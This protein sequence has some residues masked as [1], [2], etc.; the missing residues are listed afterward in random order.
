MSKPHL[1]LKEVKVSA[2]IWETK[3][4]TSGDRFDERICGLRHWCRETP[5]LTDEDVVVLCGFEDETGEVDGDWDGDE[6]LVS[7]HRFRNLSEW[8]ISRW[9]L[10]RR[11]TEVWSRLWLWDTI[12]NLCWFFCPSNDVSP[13]FFL[14]FGVICPLDKQYRREREMGRRKQN[15]ELGSC[16]IERKRKLIKEKGA[17]QLSVDVYNTFVGY[18][19]LFIWWM[20]LPFYL[21]SIACD[22]CHRW[23]T[24]NCP[25]G[26][27]TAKNGR[28]SKA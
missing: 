15:W 10:R 17:R 8:R 7:I 6:G 1:D 26:E 3:S 12:F 14:N 21:I 28:K 9:C 5:D 25:R 4:W 18:V 20:P 2:C 22:L 19:G 13:C 27:Y 11:Y 16:L 24:L 23:M